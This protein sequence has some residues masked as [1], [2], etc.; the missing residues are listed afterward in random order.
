MRSTATP[1]DEHPTVEQERG[2]ESGRLLPRANLTGVY[3][4][5]ANNAFLSTTERSATHAALVH[6]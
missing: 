5:V 1:S 2:G 3:L 4:I 6:A